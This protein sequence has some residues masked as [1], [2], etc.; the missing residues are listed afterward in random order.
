MNI[1][2]GPRNRAGSRE[3]GRPPHHRQGL[4]APAL[5]AT[6]SGSRFAPK[7]PNEMRMGAALVAFSQAHSAGDEAGLAPACLQAL[8]SPA[9]EARPESNGATVPTELPCSEVLPSSKQE[10]EP[11]IRP[12]GRTAVTLLFWGRTLTGGSAWR[13]RVPSFEGGEGLELWHRPRLE[14]SAMSK[15]KDGAKYYQPRKRVLSSLHPH[16]PSPL[17]P[18][19]RAPPAGS[20]DS[21]HDRV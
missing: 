21:P 3:P 18:L 16:R 15:R 14:P 11:L 17:L 1:T 9:H 7:V 5:P 4:P 12:S 19:G 2:A 13:S 10:A 6:S 20:P 8:G